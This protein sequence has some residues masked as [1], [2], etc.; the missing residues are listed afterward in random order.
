MF[1]ACRESSETIYSLCSDGLTDAPLNHGDRTLLRQA[2]PQSAEKR[3]VRINIARF[4]GG[5][6]V[7]E[8]VKT[9]LP[10][11]EPFFEFEISDSP[12]VLLYGPYGGKMPEG[13]FI[14]VFIG[15]ENLRPIMSEC[16]WAFGVLHEDY[17]D[18]PRYMRFARWGDDSHLLQ[19][20]KNWADIL[21]SKT[22][23]CIFLYGNKV[24]YR[25]ALFRALSRYK[26]VDAPGRSM[27]NMPGIDPVPGTVDWKAKVEFLR[28][29]KFVIAFENGS[30]PGYNTEKL[31]HAIEADCVP[32]YWGDPEIGRSFN[33]RR[34]INAHDYLPR[35]RSFVPRLPYA[36]H[37]IHR[38]IEMSFLQ[39]LCGRFNRVAGELEQRVLASGGFNALVDRIIAVDRDDE[40]YLSYLRA[41]FFIENRQPDRSAWI[42]RWREIFE[43][44][45]LV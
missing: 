1:A 39:R 33:V 42:E 17:V 8:I 29:Y 43:R 26:P 16:D 9:I 22:R 45:M 41:P 2:S 4:W 25:E 32:I 10:D 37:S 36:P 15:C 21:R 31:T 12:Q 6:T 40:L 20:D 28:A 18:H 30:A 38:G 5:A 7:E 44:A 13:R 27:N 23:F 24:H 3:R 14:K 11:L 34:F 19:Q 35:P